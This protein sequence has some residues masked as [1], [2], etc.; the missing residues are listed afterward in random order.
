MLVFK[1][2]VFFIGDLLVPKSCCNPNGDVT[3]C[4]RASSFDGPPN[5]D[6]PYSAPYR[7]NPHMYHTVSAFDQVYHKSSCRFPKAIFFFCRLNGLKK[8]KTTNWTVVL[9]TRS[10][11]D[12]PLQKKKPTSITQIVLW[13]D[14]VND[15]DLFAISAGLLWRNCTLHP[16]TRPHD[17]RN[18]DRCHCCHGNYILYHSV[19]T[20]DR[21]P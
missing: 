9:I 16:R 11:A 17:W 13:Q 19:T 14:I 20:W 4:S 18:R 15:F 12:P 8:I 10:Q 1:F 7:K 2:P 21:L 6:P 3:M 5:A